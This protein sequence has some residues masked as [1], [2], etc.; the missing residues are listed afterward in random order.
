MNN[1]IK[2]L[3]FFLALL[4][5][6]N[7]AS[8]ELQS[9]PEDL[10]IEMDPEVM[11]LRKDLEFIDSEI[12]RIDHKITKKDERKADKKKERKSNKINIPKML[13]EKKNK[14][15]LRHK[16]EVSVVNALNAILPFEKTQH[17]VNYLRKKFML[18]GVDS[19]DGF[20]FNK[21]KRQ[22][23]V[24]WIFKGLHKEGDRF[25]FSQTVK[26]SQNFSDEMN[27]ALTHGLRVLMQ[28]GADLN[29]KDDQGFTPLHLAAEGRYCKVVEF[30]C[31]AGVN[32]NEQ[33]NDGDIP[34]LVLLK[35]HRNYFE[36]AGS[37][38]IALSKNSDLLLK[39]KAGETAHDWIEFYEELVKKKVSESTN[40][41]PMSLL[42]SGFNHWFGNGPKI[43]S[44][45]KSIVAKHGN[46]S[47]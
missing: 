16:V 25:C 17:L 44:E 33:N 37:C 4:G 43:V 40:F 20:I 2:I 5:A 8:M 47:A 31:D 1:Y 39:N 11:R 23:A 27:D 41:S 12:E 18:T 34:F 42:A 21:H 7:V 29:L 13:G 32:V 36:S 46:R 38:A 15:K 22:A 45:I 35:K 19:T 24:H 28:M 26:N 3:G 14:Q 10:E 30:L 9:S 6:Q